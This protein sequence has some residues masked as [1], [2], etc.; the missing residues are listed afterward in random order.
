MV[1]MT[2][3]VGYI[4]MDMFDIDRHKNTQGYDPLEH[5]K[6][7][8]S[9]IDFTNLKFA[10]LVT[11]PA[12]VLHEL[13]HK[14]TS[15]ALGTAATFHASYFWLFIGA[16]LKW[17]NTG[18]VFFVPGY[19]SHSAAIPPLYSAAIAFAGPAVNL[20][21]W[22]GSWIALKTVKKLNPMTLKVLGFT[23]QINMF[24]FFF[25]MIPFGFFDGAK[26]LDGVLT[27]F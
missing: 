9:G 20:L 3:V 18:F 26:V 12:I 7:V 16:M 4:F 11:A 2:V 22:L 23:K 13:A 8:R 14:F 5:Y 24:L 10:I 25:N 1:I 19:V 21:L 15:L 27:L 17:F 6:H